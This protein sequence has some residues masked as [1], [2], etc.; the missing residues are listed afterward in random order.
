MTDPFDVVP[1]PDLVVPLSREA[2]AAAQAYHSGQCSLLYAVAST[3]SLR[4]GSLFVGGPHEFSAMVQDLQTET[5]D[6]ARLAADDG[7]HADGLSGILE[8][9]DDWLSAYEEWDEEGQ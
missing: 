2:I 8:A 4:P 9:C 5:G 3:G 1:S 6:A 7:D